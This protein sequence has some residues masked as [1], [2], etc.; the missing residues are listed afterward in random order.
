MAYDGQIVGD[1]EIGEAEPLLQ[2]LEQVDDLALDR[3][4]EGGDGLV[5]DDDARIDGQR[6]GDA[7]P[8]ALAARQL[9]GIAQRHVGEE[10]DDL[11][12][13][14]DPVVNL[15]L[16][17]D[18]VHADRLGDDLAHRHARI[19][20]GIGVLEDDLH[21]LA[22]GDHLLAVERRQIHALEADLAAGRLV[23][24][25]H[26]A[27]ERGFPAPQL[28]DETQRLAALDA[29]GDA[30]DGAHQLVPTKQPD[31]DGEI[32]LRVARWRGCRRYRG[33]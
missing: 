7:D 4:V 19:E 25:Q 28:A 27:A 12:Q 13:L 2:L 17:Q 23:E 9:V 16:G 29:D 5:A 11:Q 18:A 8:L 15:R 30:V 26:Q 14:G 22:H 24:A 10:P 21:L 20:G 31:A 6:P 3:D 1:E 33:R 32:F